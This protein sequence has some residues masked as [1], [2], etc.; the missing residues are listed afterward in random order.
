ME[1]DDI[2]EYSL[3]T[4]HSEEAGVKIRKNIFKVTAI[5]T[6]I[7]VAEV[8]VGIKLNREI[9]SPGLWQAIK[10]A[11]IIL[12]LVKAGYIVLSFMRLGDE[13]QN[14]RRVILAPYVLFISYLIFI[15]ITES[16]YINDMLR[17]FVE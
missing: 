11:Y 2:I 9:A 16:N 13:R 17:A 12:T 4:H 3:N 6:V 14:I 8:F 5:L 7:T 10:Y 15:C 1:R